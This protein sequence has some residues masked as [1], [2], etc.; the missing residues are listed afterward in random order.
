MSAQ[1][2]GPLMLRAI[3]G[4]LILGM[5]AVWLTDSVRLGDASGPTLGAVASHRVRASAQ[6]VAAC[7]SP[8]TVDHPLR[9]WIGGDSLAASLGQALGDLS[10]STGVVA[11]TFDSHVSSGLSTPEFFD[12]PERAA[13]EMA[14]VD[15]EVVVFIIGTNDWPVPSDPTLDATGA[16]AWKATY[17]ALVTEM[18]DVMA[19]PGRVVYWIGG[20]ALADDTK[21]QG[22]QAIDEV[23]HT[24]VQARPDATYVDGYH[25]FTDANGMYAASLPGVDGKLVRVRTDDGIHFTAAGAELLGT[26]V[27]GLLDEHC[28]L[29]RQADTDHPQRVM[30]APGS[31]TPSA[32]GSGEPT[33]G[34]VPS[35]TT[36]TST[37]ESTTSTST[38]TSSSTST[39]TTSTTSSTTTPST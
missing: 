24:V 13:A 4:M 1:K 22:V 11:P 3:L 5:L 37:S 30:Q 21:D 34:D 26:E 14:R 25:L 32:T 23:A 31:A 10:A 9:L 20:P 17:A 28:A 12:W 39:S 7:R 38:S 2:L 35:D 27:F 19:A 29:D 33:D 15:P 16:P 18:L 6:P 8:L 36:S